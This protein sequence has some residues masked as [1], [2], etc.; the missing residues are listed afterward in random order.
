VS[1]AHPGATIE[2][3]A[4]KKQSKRAA[5]V[6]IVKSEPREEGGVAP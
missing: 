2:V 6:R 5:A 4:M 3:H 1:A